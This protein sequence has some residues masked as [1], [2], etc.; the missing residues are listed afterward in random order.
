MCD[1]VAI[2]IP[3]YNSSRFLRGCIESVISQT[4]KDIEIVMINDGSTDDSLNIIEYYSKKDK[5]IKY[6]SIKNGG[7]SIARNIGIKMCESNK[8]M[9]LDSDDSI[10]PNLVETLMNEGGDFDF[11]M[12]GYLVKEIN[13][14]RE[15]KYTCPGFSGRKKEFLNQLINYLIPPYLLG[16]C[17]KLFDKR[18][19]EKHNI[20]FPEDISFGEDAEFVLSYLENAETIKCIEYIGYIYNQY[21]LGTLSKRFRKDKMDI[22]KRINDHIIK[23]LNDN[24]ANNCLLNICN[25]YIQNYVEYT[26]ELII[27]QLK[28]KEKK[29]LFLDKG[30][31]NYV[32]DYAM[33]SGPHSL[34]QN[35]LLLSLKRNS[36][37]LA[38]CIFNLKE[39]I[40]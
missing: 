40:L 23:L 6:R 8:I 16:P 14:N 3:V 32:L 25:R 12:C 24:E 1:K 28:Y 27:S 38:Y 26:R 35:I 18:L 19:L 29:K 17:F 20:K 5:R 30:K 31:S 39:K 22:Y 13:K 2:V 11:V 33:K 4:Y 9:F 21:D 34:A 36:F 7:A 15:Y 37:F 10:A